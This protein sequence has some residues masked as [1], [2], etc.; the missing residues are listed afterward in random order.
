MAYHADSDP[1][2]MFIK[3]KFTN[4]EYHLIYC[5]FLSIIYIHLY[6]LT[7]KKRKE[8]VKGSYIHYILKNFKGGWIRTLYS[9]SPECITIIFIFKLFTYKH[10]LLPL[11]LILK[12]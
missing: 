12:N 11:V 3:I 4:I 7:Q 8:G 10:Y 2:E 1:K 9:P 5:T 6:K